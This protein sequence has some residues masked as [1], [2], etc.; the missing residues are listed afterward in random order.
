MFS[1]AFPGSFLSSSLSFRLVQKSPVR[2]L[3]TRSPA[4][5]EVF[6]GM[7]RS[8][9]VLLI[10][11]FTIS[12]ETTSKRSHESIAVSRKRFAFG[13]FQRQSSTVPDR[14]RKIPFRG[15]SQ[16]SRHCLTT[17]AE[18]PPSWAARFLNL[19]SGCCVY[20]HSMPSRGSGPGKAGLR[21]LSSR[22]GIPHFRSPQH[23]YSF[24][25]HDFWFWIEENVF[26]VYS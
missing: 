22:A 8:R 7:E 3:Q 9:A 20:S 19:P 6:A 4:V 5:L 16:T 24:L 13:R 14:A 17:S 15:S 12:I 1:L 23:T 25:I 2:S 18:T 21:I 26:G 10:E 11:L